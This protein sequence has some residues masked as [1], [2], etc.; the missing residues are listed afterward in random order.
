MYSLQKVQ[1]KSPATEVPAQL[2]LRHVVRANSTMQP[3]AAAAAAAGSCYTSTQQAPTRQRLFGLAA[4]TR[5][6]AAQPVHATP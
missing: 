5:R 1:R 4:H 6:S 2:Q 3:T